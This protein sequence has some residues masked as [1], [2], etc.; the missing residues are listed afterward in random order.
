METSNG[1]GFAVLFKTVAPSLK[2]ENL[3][4]RC[5]N[6]EMIEALG[7]LALTK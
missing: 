4:V 1:N 5:K 6:R 2:Y 3:N 7:A